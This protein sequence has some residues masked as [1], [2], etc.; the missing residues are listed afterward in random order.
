MVGTGCGGGAV[1]WIGV[2]GVV[3]Q[4]AGCGGAGCGGSRFSGVR[5]AVHSRI[6]QIRVLIQG[7]GLGLER[8]GL[9]ERSTIASAH[10]SSSRTVK[11]AV[12]N[13]TVAT[14]APPLI[15]SIMVEEVR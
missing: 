5:S 9:P 12:R 14:F 1:R 2:Q 4:W 10:L 11:A 8:R 7:F 13:W 3:V 6:A 15:V